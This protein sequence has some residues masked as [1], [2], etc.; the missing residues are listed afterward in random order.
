M[1]SKYLI[2]VG[3]VL[4]SFG[5]F[6][7]SGCQSVLNKDDILS[8]TGSVLLAWPFLA[9]GGGCLMGAFILRLFDRFL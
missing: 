4:L 7:P 2:I 9:I 5:F 1:K 6:L 3:L 8:C